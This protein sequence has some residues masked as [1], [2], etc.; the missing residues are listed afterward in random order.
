MQLSFTQKSSRL[1]WAGQMALSLTVNHCAVVNCVC[2]LTVAKWCWCHLCVCVTGR[3]TRSLRRRGGRWPVCSTWWSQASCSSTSPA[4]GWT[5]S[6]PLLSQ[7][8]SQ[9]MTSC[10]PTEVRTTLIK[11]LITWEIKFAFIF[12][13]IRGT[14]RTSCKFY[15][16]RLSLAFWDRI[17]Q[18]L[19][20]RY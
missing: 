4:S 2:V 1:C 14:I 17:F 15:D 7:D 9:T 6:K 10:V 8:P 13:R 20:H 19:L 5:N 18:L 12:W 3:V 16:T 11:R